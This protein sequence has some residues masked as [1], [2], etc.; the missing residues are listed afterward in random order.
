MQAELDR[1]AA[2]SQQLLAVQAEMQASSDDLTERCTQLHAD[3]LHVTRM[4][5]QRD[6]ELQGEQGCVLKRRCELKILLGLN[7]ATLATLALEHDAVFNCLSR[8]FEAHHR[9]CL[10]C[11]ELPAEM[12]QSM[13]DKDVQLEQC[14]GEAARLTGELASATAALAAKAS[15]LSGVGCELEAARG[16][17]A[18]ATAAMRDAHDQLI[19][20]QVRGLVLVLVAGALCS[21]CSVQAACLPPMLLACL[22]VG[23]AY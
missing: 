15:E 21:G 6:N 2:R 7:S 19:E 4:L 17:L 11:I 14:R 20:L 3:N 12:E 5:A 13:E 23:F 10:P 8:W 1:R 18:E 9:V 16:K 22:L